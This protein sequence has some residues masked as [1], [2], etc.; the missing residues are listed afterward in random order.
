MSSSSGFARFLLVTLSITGLYLALN[1]M[2]MTLA[3]SIYRLTDA[4][5]E[6]GWQREAAE[7]AQASRRHQQLVP[8]SSRLGA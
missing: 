3:P 8:H 2:W 1:A 4:R 5:V 7:V 6:A